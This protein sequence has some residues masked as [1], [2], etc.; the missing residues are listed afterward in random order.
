MNSKG[1]SVGA[2]SQLAYWEVPIGGADA[3]M[4]TLTVL[5]LMPL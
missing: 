4:K 2:G 3:E 5:L 1:A